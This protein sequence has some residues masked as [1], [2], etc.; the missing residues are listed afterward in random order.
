VGTLETYAGILY[1]LRSGEATEPTGLAV[2]N[3]KPVRVILAWD[4]FA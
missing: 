2:L 1:L 3:G 4:R